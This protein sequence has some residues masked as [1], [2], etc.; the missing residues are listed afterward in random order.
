MQKK[1]DQIVQQNAHAAKQTRDIENRILKGLT[2]HKEI[3][4][5]LEDDELIDVL[6][7]AKITGEEIAMFMRESVESEKMIEQT[8]TTFRRVAYRAQILFFTI[9]DL[10]VIDPMYQYSLQWFSNLFSSSVDNSQKTAD[11]EHRIKI[12]ND[13]FTL[14]LYDNVCRS[15]FEKDKLLFSFKLTINIMFGDNRMDAQE[16][17]FFL[18]GPSG[19]IKVAPN[20]T[21]W[22]GDLEWAET[23]KQLYVMSRTL[24]C[25]KGFEEFFIDN[26]TEF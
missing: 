22:L 2:K 5:I 15:L 18:A 25:F 3:V 13:H 6:A 14:N 4:A 16:L 26:N 10:A 9:V 19:E 24:P 8:R 11:N 21:D 23:Y 12:L 20:P 7:E 1:K 17:R